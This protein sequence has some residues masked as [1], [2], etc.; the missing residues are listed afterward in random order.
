M[1]ASTALL[2]CALT[3]F[4]SIPTS[5]Y[6]HSVNAR[7]ELVI[8][9]LRVVEDSWRTTG[10]GPWTFCGLMTSLAGP[11]QNPAVYTRNWLNTWLVAPYIG[12]YRL[13]PRNHM[14]SVINNWPKQW[15]GN[16]DLTRAPFRLLAIVHRPDLNEGRFVF[17]LQTASGTPRAMTIIFEYDLSTNLM[18]RADWIWNWHLLGSMTPGTEQYNAHLQFLTDKFARTPSMFDRIGL[19][20]LR[21]SDGEVA[22]FSNEWTD[23]EFRQW[24]YGWGPTFVLSQD[25]MTQT[26]HNSFNETY[27]GK[28]S[29][30]DYINQNEQFILAGNHGVGLPLKR[31]GN[32]INVFYGWGWNTGGINN[33]QARF[34][35]SMATCSGCHFGDTDNF[36]TSSHINNRYAGVEAQLSQFFGTTPLRDTKGQYRVHDEMG[37]RVTL[38]AQTLQQYG[39][40]YSYNAAWTGGGGGA[41]AYAGTPTSGGTNPIPARVH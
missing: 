41:P 5:S 37:R 22:F 1:R 2:A 26:P 23:W 30:R 31:A 17:G 12:G 20:S 38:F 35:F 40:C 9:D 16:L 32:D 24:V 21:S 18:S 6:A 10:C 15:D 28:N 4:S 3:I 8:T 27:S 34:L 14:N 11:S 39:F 29:L 33:Q 19:K 36:V 7:Q 25:S 13:P